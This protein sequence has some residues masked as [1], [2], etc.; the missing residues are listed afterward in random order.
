M[1][2]SILHFYK[3][4]PNKN[5]ILRCKNSQIQFRINFILQKT[6][7]YKSLA[8]SNSKNI[9]DSKIQKSFFSKIAMI[10]CNQSEKTT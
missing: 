3:T 1:K 5:G 8:E 2:S 9:F 7:N 4:T 6:M 10:M